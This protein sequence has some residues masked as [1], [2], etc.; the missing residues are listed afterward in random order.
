MRKLFLPYTAGTAVVIFMWWNY[1]STVSNIQKQEQPTDGSSS[2]QFQLV[3]EIAESVARLQNAHIAKTLNESLQTALQER[4][5]REA[6]HDVIDDA[7]VDANIIY[8]FTPANVTAMPELPFINGLRNPCFYVRNA[9]SQDRYKE[10][11][12]NSHAKHAYW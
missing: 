2:K 4:S 6:E 1:L 7:T 10:N 11:R 9:P 8:S 5:I 3:K 12:F